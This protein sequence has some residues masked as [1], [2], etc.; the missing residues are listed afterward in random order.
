MSSQRP[1]KWEAGGW[2]TRSRDDTSRGRRGHEPRVW[3]ARRKRQPPLEPPGGPPPL[4]ALASGLP[5]S[6]PCCF[7]ALH[8]WSF[9]LRALGNTN[10]LVW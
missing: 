4:Q 7:E 5:V 1:C 9:I 8:L 6:K 2:S 10:N 3:G